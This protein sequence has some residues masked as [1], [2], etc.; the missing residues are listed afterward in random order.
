MRSVPEREQSVKNR[1]KTAIKCYE[2]LE[3]AR[4]SNDIREMFLAIIVVSTMSS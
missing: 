1:E 2:A 3:N 4:F